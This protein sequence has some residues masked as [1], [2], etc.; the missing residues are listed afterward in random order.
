ME[1]LSLETIGVLYNKAHSRKP[2]HRS[3]PFAVYV[4]YD[5]PARLLH[6]PRTPFKVMTNV[7]CLLVLQGLNELIWDSWC[8]EVFVRYLGQRKGPAGGLRKGEAVLTSV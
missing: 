5:E 4:L 1:R 8:E 7:R 2:A 6:F 3:H